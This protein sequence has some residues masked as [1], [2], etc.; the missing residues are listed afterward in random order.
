MTTPERRLQNAVAQANQRQREKAAGL[1]RVIVIIP[2]DRRD[3]LRRI[4][5]SWQDKTPPPHVAK[6]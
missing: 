6:T 2:E 3:E 4:V 1:A 5:K